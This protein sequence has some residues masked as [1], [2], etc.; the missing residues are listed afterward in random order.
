MPVI[1]AVI[2]YGTNVVALWMTFHP[3]NFVGIRIWQPED[4]PL[5]LFGWQGKCSPPLEGW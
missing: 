5:G 2:G 3:I 4:S 1:S